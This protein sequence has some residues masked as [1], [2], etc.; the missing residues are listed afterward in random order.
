MKIF[1]GLVHNNGEHVGEVKNEIEK[2][3]NE[4]LNDGDEVAISYS[5]Y[6]PIVYKHNVIRLL[7]RRFEYFKLGLRWNNYRKGKNG[8]VFFMVSF[9]EFIKVKNLK[10]L[11][12][13]S[14][15]ETYV[16]DKHLRLWFSA[17]EDSDFIVIFED[18]VVF[19]KESV[20]EMAKIVDF[21]KNS[22]DNVFYFDLAGGLPISVLGVGKLKDLEFKND[23]LFGIGA[24]QYKKIV[25]NTACGYMLSR[26]LLEYFLL[27]LIENPYYRDTGIDWLINR[28][29]MHVENKEIKSMHFNPPIFNHGSFT[30][31][32]QSWQSK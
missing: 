32:H 25:T 31:E 9:L 27:I 29:A 13:N 16:T 6:Q 18:D 23:Q 20:K 15:I 14:L 17:I 10:K 2:L 26:E 8:F 1:V 11:A 19:K 7:K 3:K 22:K 30:G 28:L 5:S 4:L 12:R 21:A 24:V